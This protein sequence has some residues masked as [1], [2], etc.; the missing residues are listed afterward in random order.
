MP[1]STNTYPAPPTSGSGVGGVIQSPDLNSVGKSPRRGIRDALMARDVIQTLIQANRNRNIVN[2]RI[3]AKFNAERP[4]DQSKLNE[5]GLG[6]RNNF[7]TK[8]LSSIVDKVFPRFVEA[9]NAVKYLTNSSLS[10]EHQNASEKT[11]KFRDGITKLIRSRK[12]WVTLLEDI[13][14][15]NSMFGNTGCGW[16]DEFSWFPHHFKQ[17]EFYISDGTKQDS[18]NAQVC[19]FREVHLPH[20][21]LEYIEDRE[22]AVDAGFNIKATVEV[23]NNASPAQLR[24][25]LVQGGTLEFWYQ[26][27]VRELTVGSSY[28]AGASVI[29]VY[30]LLVREV[31]GKVSHYRLAGEGLK[32]IFSKEDRFNS[33]E[34][35]VAFFSYEKGN[36][37]MHG[38]KG[39][40]RAIYELAAMLDRNRNEIVDR[41]IMSGKTLIQGD[42]RQLHKF[43]MSVIGASVI[44]PTG[45]EVLT[46]KVDGNVEPSLKL[47]AYFM[48]LIDGIVGS[49]SPPHAQGEAFRSPQAW[50]LLAEREEEGRDFRVSRFLTQFTCLVQTMQRRICDPEVVDKDAKKFQKTMLEIMSKEEFKELG[51]CPV[52]ETIR[53]LTPLDRQMIA[54]VANEKRGNPLYNQKALE[55][56]DLTARV[57]ADFA[58]R[59]LMPENDPVETAE[60]Q[61]LQQLELTLLSGGQPVPVSPRD[62]HLIHLGILLPVL[63]Q[64]AGQMTQGAVGTA[65]FEASVSHASDHVNAF[66][67]GGG[68]KAKVKPIQDFLS[69]AMQMVARLQQL[70]DKAEEVA[71]YTDQMAAEDEQ[72]AALAAQQ[73]D[74][75]ALTGSPI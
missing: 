12:G 70:D 18:E 52:A 16:L 11:D 37:T 19:V 5:E 67:S 35:C 4:Y 2:A 13:A 60:Q 25:D 55:M 21:L 51:Q 3:M 44:V 34:E 65:V 28:M 9:A 45:W 23:I 68:D 33:M 46:Q 24:S 54:T 17:D 66:L 49:V 56:E 43:K 71:G 63:E 10:E 48:S 36:G 31:T 57:G 15:Y 6:W 26:N 27:M 62:A 1:D 59:V 50:A 47:D 64:M 39:I 53:D 42:I 40:G 22:A 14:I 30:S 20:E 29:Q 72:A 61:R 32:E 8:P 74:E 58:K 7:T 41:S 38:S 73:A 69:K 75:A